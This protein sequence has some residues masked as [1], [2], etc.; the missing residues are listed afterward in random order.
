MTQIRI[1]ILLQVQKTSH[2]LTLKP[3]VQ[4]YKRF[5]V[6]QKNFLKITLNRHSLSALRMK[7]KNGPRVKHS[8][9]WAHLFLIFL[10]KCSYLQ[11][12]PSVMDK[13]KL[14]CELLVFADVGERGKMIVFS[15]SALSSSQ[16]HLYFLPKGKCGEQNLRPI[17][18][19]I[20]GTLVQR[21]K[22]LI[23]HMHKDFPYPL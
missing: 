8:L 19:I 7:S 20:C 17:L 22:T 21:D 11:S 3:L 1:R 2:A 5:L 23:G 13:W 6:S 15:S 14:V 10:C 12:S 18:H 4:L 16:S 9:L